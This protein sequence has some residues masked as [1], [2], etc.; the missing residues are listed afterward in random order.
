MATIAKLVKSG[1]VET[2]TSFTPFPKGTVGVRTV[3]QAVT[4]A[5]AQVDNTVYRMIPV[6]KGETIHA[7]TLVSTDLDTAG[8]PAIVLDVGAYNSDTATGDSA[9]TSTLFSN[10]STVA[11]AGG[12]LRV[13]GFDAANTATTLP[14][15]FTADTHID[16]HIEVPAGTGQAG[17]LVMNAYIS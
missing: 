8:S 3:T 15:T 13:S 17:D 2:N 10:G 11:Q 12:V 9:T 16:I 1:M 7:L 4:A 6:S 14:H 5:D